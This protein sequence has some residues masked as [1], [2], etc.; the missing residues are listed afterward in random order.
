MA[1]KLS[2]EEKVRRLEEQLRALTRKSKDGRPTLFDAKQIRLLDTACS[3][4]GITEQQVADL[5][6]C[7]RDVLEK[8]IRRTYKLTFTA[9]RK[10]K[11]GKMNFHL[12]S[13]QVQVAMGQEEIRTEDGK[14]KQQYVAPNV[15]MLIWL[16]K[17]RLDQKDTHETSIKSGDGIPFQLVI[18]A[19][20]QD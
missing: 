13:K 20:K 15:S 12:L 8:F 7:H 4:P 17:N 11:E 19:P 1:K 5:L 2:V 18:N 9:F 3:F 10:Q 6:D 16:G 14:I